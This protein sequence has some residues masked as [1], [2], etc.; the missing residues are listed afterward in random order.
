MKILLRAAMAAASFASIG[1]AYAG[2]GGGTVSNTWFT[3]LPCV[4]AQAPAQ[5]APMAAAQNGPGMQVFATQSSKG[6][7]LFAPNPNQGGNS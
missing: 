2:D 3:Q 4:V 5:N 6:T 7:W 1:S